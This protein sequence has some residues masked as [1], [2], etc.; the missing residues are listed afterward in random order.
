MVISCVE[1]STLCRLFVDCVRFD[2]GVVDIATGVKLS[3]FYVTV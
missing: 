2:T 1:K 3:N